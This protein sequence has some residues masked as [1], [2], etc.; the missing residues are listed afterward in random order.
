MFL[1]GGRSRTGKLLPPK[2][3]LLNMVVDAALALPERKVW[4]VP[5]SIGYEQVLEAKSYEREL[6]GGEKPKEDA[7]GLL[8]SRD[9]LRHRY[10][11]IS[12][13]VGQLL[14]L[15]EIDAELGSRRD[16]PL[17]PAKR[18][19]LVTRLGNRVMDE[20][21]RVTAVTPGSLSALVLLCHRQ[22]G[23]SHDELIGRTER[24]LAVLNGFRARVSPALAT[25][26]G[27]LR[28]E[29]IRNRCRCSPTPSSS[30]FTKPPR[31]RA[32]AKS[33]AAPRRD[34]A[35]T[36]SS[37]TRSGFRSTRPK[38]DRALFVER[39]LVALA[40]LAAPTPE[41]ELDWCARPR[42]RALALVQVD[43]RFRADQ[44]FE[45]IFEETRSA[46][47]SSRSSSSPM[48]AVSPAAGTPVGRAENGSSVTPRFW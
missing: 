22:R 47:A 24:L 40:V 34:P 38:M 46:M 11:R 1:E 6:S 25:S 23:L 13:Q 4:F 45:S 20:I 29:S 28:P 2:F 3:G 7:A 32:A 48:S 31:V 14:T 12:M 15:D 35:R 27:A 41:P 39:A 26:S 37:V 42:A 44:P 33:G 18:R 21:N 43:F 19:S 36:T 5:V 16:V 8:K 30:K 17:S 10:G 9:L